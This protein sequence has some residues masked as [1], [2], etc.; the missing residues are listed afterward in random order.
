LAVSKWETRPSDPWDPTV[1]GE[2]EIRVKN[3]FFECKKFYKEDVAKKSPHAD[4]A[5]GLIN[6]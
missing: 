4:I 1:E 6:Q 2:E 5:R 3:R